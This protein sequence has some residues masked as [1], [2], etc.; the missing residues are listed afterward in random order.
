MRVS[1]MSPRV[2]VERKAVAPMLKPMAFRHIAAEDQ[3]RHVDSA[4][5]A[6]DGDF[7]GEDALDGCG[8]RSFARTG[9]R[10]GA[11]VRVFTRGRGARAAVRVGLAARMPWR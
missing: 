2:S 4:G 5:V 6:V 7:R 9:T 11:R 3:H 1:L 10:A 8:D